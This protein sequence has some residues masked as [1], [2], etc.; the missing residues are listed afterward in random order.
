MERKLNTTI[1]AIAFA[2]LF[3]GC[4]QT[5]PVDADSVD[6]RLPPLVEDEPSE[7]RGEP[8]A[9]AAPPTTAMKALYESEVLQTMDPTKPETL[10]AAIAQ[11]DEVLAREPKNSVVLYLRGWARCLSSADPQFV[12]EDIT[13]AIESR[14][15][16]V[17][18]LLV[19][20]R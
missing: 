1:L 15:V 4:R 12:I 20:F 18:G 5:T 7:F 16:E 11:F 8:K 14:N 9:V 19:S 2:L 17:F 6:R 3:L 10:R 13:A